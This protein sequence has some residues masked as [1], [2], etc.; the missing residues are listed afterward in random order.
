MRRTFV[1]G[2]FVFQAASCSDA[3]SPDGLSEPVRGLMLSQQSSGTDALLQAVSPVND[4]I[5]WVSGHRATYARTSDGGSTWTASVMPDAEG[6]QFRDVAAFNERA[7]YLMSAGSG[8]LSRIYRTDDGGRNWT[9]QYMADHPEAFLDCIDFWDVN[10][11][12]A[13]GDA[14]DG[15]PFLLMTMDGGA[16][17]ERVPADR[18][19]LAQEGE[20]GFAASGTCVVADGE[21]RAWIAMGNA[22]R[23][24]VLRTEDYGQ[25]WSVVD[26]PV[27]AG[28][29]SGLT[30]VRVMS[31]GAGLAMGGRIG[32]DSVRSANVAITEDGGLT[33]TTGGT[34]VMDGPVYGSALL[35][36]G[37]AV[38]VGPRG[39]EWSADGGRTWQSSVTLTYWAVA[40]SSSGSGWAVG[41][42]GRIT[43]LGFVGR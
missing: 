18:L 33:W 14:V 12:L 4:D 11:G 35:V 43:K 7:A 23:A 20:G 37:A 15:V 27:V 3:P 34:L 1:V 29:G 26:V 17:W 22:E 5:V 9:L 16:T 19:P 2:L 10:R 36:S 21:G 28:A 24:R 38:A 42:A 40:F 13:Y 6:L 32:Q 41:P 8:E 31:D 25:S 39:L 30:T